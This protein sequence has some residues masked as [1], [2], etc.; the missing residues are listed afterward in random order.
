MSKKRKVL[1]GLSLCVALFIAGFG[2]YMFTHKP[3]MTAEQMIV[4][5]QAD[6]LPIN[7]YIVFD[8]TTDLNKLLGRPNQ[9]ISKVNFAD[10]RLEQEEGT[11][12]NGGSIETFKNSGDLNIRKDHLD[13]VA[14]NMPVFTQYI[15]VNGNYLLRLSSDLT[16]E[17]AEEYKKAF[18]SIK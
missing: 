18:M 12:P 15:F 2:L 9:Y 3:D 16:P 10:S 4:K 11:D 13:N 7:N 5:M 8:E 1:I 17:Q 6:K 14:K